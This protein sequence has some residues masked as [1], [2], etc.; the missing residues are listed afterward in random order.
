[1][2]IYSYTCI[3]IYIPINA[4]MSSTAHVYMHRLKKLNILSFP[5]MVFLPSFFFFKSLEPISDCD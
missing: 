3:H 2:Y 1:M 5:K 4:Q